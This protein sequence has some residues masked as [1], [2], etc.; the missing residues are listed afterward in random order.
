MCTYLYVYIHTHV[1]MVSYKTHVLSCV[2]V[3]ETSIGLQNQN[4]EFEF[5][6]VKKRWAWR[7]E[8]QV[9]WVLIFKIFFSLSVYVS[10]RGKKAVFVIPKWF[11]C[12]FFQK[13]PSLYHIIY[14]LSWFIW[15]YVLI[16]SFNW[17]FEL[18]EVH[19]GDL[20]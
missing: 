11:V 3:Y 13:H 12:S 15:L 9:L 1:C 8:E 6:I 4:W 18:I 14:I 5:Q 10:M 17:C 19:M 16:I 7:I 20:G 2:R